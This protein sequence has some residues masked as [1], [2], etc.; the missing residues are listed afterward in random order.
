M[1]SSS[2]RGEGRSRAPLRL[3]TKSKV[4]TGVSKGNHIHSGNL[5]T[6]GIPKMYK[7]TLGYEGQI[8]L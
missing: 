7:G 6:L 3:L 8:S 5:W 1:L 2:L 4:R